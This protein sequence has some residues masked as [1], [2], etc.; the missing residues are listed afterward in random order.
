MSNKETAGDIDNILHYK[1][2]TMII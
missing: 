1:K 2:S